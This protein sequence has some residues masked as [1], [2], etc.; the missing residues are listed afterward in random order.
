[1]TQINEKN[2]LYHVMLVIVAHHVPVLL[3]LTGGDTGG[4]LAGTD[5]LRDLLV[6]REVLI[7]LQFLITVD[8]QYKL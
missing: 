2:N 7:D 4:G 3:R 6:E 8:L 5:V 1:M